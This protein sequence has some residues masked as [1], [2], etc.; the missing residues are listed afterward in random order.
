MDLSIIITS[1]NAKQILKENLEAVFASVGKF[2]CEV[3]VVDNNSFDGSADMVKQEFPVVNLIRNKKNL[4]FARANNQAIK[5]ADGDFILLLNQDMLVYPETLYRTAEWM[6]KNEQASVAGCHLIDR[7]GDSMPHVRKYPTVWDQLIIVL[8]LPHLIPGF[9]NKYL[10][11]DFDYS[12]PAKVDSVRGSFFVIRRDMFEKIGGLDERYFFWFEEVDYCQSVAAAGGE[13]W[14]T[15][16]AKCLD[17]VGHSARE[18]PRGRAQKIMRDSMLKYFK[19]WHKSWEYW[20]L[21]L[22]WPVGR[23]MTWAGEKVKFKRKKRIN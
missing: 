10:L 15:P 7:D 4:G 21:R 8:K 19:K 6:K 20:L 17:Y 2:S 1:Y 18:M 3:F 23:L 22:A 11:K 16:A 12:R 13:V 14:Y 5:K 9:L